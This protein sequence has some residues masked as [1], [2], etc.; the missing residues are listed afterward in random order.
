MVSIDPAGRTSGIRGSAAGP[1]STGGRGP[2]ASIPRGVAPGVSPAQPESVG[3]REEGHDCGESQ[4][5]VLVTIH[6][7]VFAGVLHECLTSAEHGRRECC[8]EI[9][10]DDRR[11]M[12]WVAAGQ[13]EFVR[14][15]ETD[16]A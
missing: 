1:G 15:G 5:E 7:R 10:V 9:R 13:V 8:V 2:T 6:G 11:V 4:P 12:T 16:R 3:G 14:P